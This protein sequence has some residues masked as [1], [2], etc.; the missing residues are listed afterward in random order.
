M[1]PEKLTPSRWLVA[2]CAKESD[3]C[4]FSINVAPEGLEISI[5][6][7]SRN[8]GLWSELSSVVIV[9]LPG[10]STAE[11]PKNSGTLRQVEEEV[12]VLVDTRYEC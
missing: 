12:E 3:G 2:V 11:R 4:N 10:G 5:K 9:C 1:S 8:N 6:H 7:K